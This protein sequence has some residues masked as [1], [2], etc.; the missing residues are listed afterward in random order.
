M[1]E[2]QDWT[3]EPSTGP[4]AHGGGEADRGRGRGDTRGARRGG[5]GGLVTRVA[6]DALHVRRAIGDPVRAGDVTLLPVARVLGGSGS[7]WGSGELGAGTRAAETRGEGAGAGGGGG[8]AVRVRP[9]G[10]YVVQ[11]SHVEWQPALDLTRVILVGQLVGAVAVMSLSW[12]LRPRR[13][14]RRR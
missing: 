13:W 14:R 2:D 7:G 5:R 8:F 1:T 12:A 9:L 3:G 10:V 11:G 6:G 4:D